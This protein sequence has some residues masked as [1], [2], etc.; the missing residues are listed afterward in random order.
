MPE[1]PLLVYDGDCGFC[2]RW[3]ARWR[4]LTG[5]RVAYA[6][7]QECAARFPEIPLERFRSAVQL[8]DPDGAWT[9]GAGAALGALRGVPVLGL[10][11]R[12]Y[13]FVP[14]FAAACEGFYRWVA[15]N[16]GRW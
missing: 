12:L 15:A 4:H 1:R 6:P 2:R 11:H 10:A 9:S 5:D 8:R 16:R 7:Y 13:A 14:P 3:I